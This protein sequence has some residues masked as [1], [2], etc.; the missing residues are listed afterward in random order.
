MTHVE[1]AV[2]R[3]ARELLGADPDKVT[4]ETTW[5]DLKA[6]SLDRVEL[7]MAFEEEFGIELTD[8]D[9]ETIHT[10][11]EMIALIERKRG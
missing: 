6:D 10:V 7:A 1:A 3:I 2:K 8:D 11:G 4:P 5:D 9:I